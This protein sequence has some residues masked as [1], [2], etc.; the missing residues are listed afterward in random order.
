MRHMD[1]KQLLHDFTFWLELEGII[2]E[3]PERTEQDWLDIVTAF[4][5]ARKDD[6]K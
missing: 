5:E 2:E 3:N 4:L 6:T 1:E